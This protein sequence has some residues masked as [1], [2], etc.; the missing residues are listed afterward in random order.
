[1]TLHRAILLIVVLGIVSCSRSKLP[2]SDSTPRADQAPPQAIDL[3]LKATAFVERLG[4]GEFVEATGDFD[5][6]MRNAMPAE[7]LKKAWQTVATQAGAYQKPLSSKQEKTAEYETVHVTCA[8]AK[9][10]VNVRVVYD[11]DAKIAGLFFSPAQAPGTPQG[12]EETWKGT[13]NV[14]TAQLRLVFHLFKQKDGGYA[15]TMD[16]P[17][18]GARGLAVDTVRM[19]G[20]QM[21]LE[22]KSLQVVFDGALSKNGKVINGNFKQR[23]QSF[24]LVL[25]KF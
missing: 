8:F 25:E 4:K 15:G 17:D 19:Q 20:D 1:M 6:R 12:E 16:S 13:L 21:H 10:K 18:Q 3:K 24:P 9:L 22:L 2:R 14:G 11:Q 5:A 23:G 7:E